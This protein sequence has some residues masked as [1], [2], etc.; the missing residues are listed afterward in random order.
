MLYPQQCCKPDNI[1]KQEEDDKPIS[2]NVL[3]DCS[4]IELRLRDLEETGIHFDYQVYADLKHAIELTRESLPEKLF[5][6][7][8]LDNPQPSAYSNSTVYHISS[9]IS[10]NLNKSFAN[11]INKKIEFNLKNANAEIS[12]RDISLSIPITVIS[13]NASKPNIITSYE[14]TLKASQLTSNVIKEHNTLTII[15][16]YSATFDLFEDIN[17]ITS[18]DTKAT[19][20]PNATGLMELRE[21]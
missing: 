11:Y 1:Q 2:E 9:F 10:N 17:R 15:T 16:T 13:A 18:V 6:S 19:I 3:S 21:K 4:L 5:I 12:D 8:K 14:T 7:F 20:Y